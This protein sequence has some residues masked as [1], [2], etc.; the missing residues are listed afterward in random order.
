[1]KNLIP[2]LILFAYLFINPACKKDK[3]KVYK[4][5]VLTG[6]APQ[7]LEELQDF[8][9]KD[10]NVIE[11]GLT[12]YGQDWLENL[13][14]LSNLEKVNGFVTIKNNENLIS[15]EGLDN[16][17]FIYNKDP[18]NGNLSIMNNNNLTNIDGL[19]GL[20]IIESGMF[21]AENEKLET[22]EGLNNLQELHSLYIFNNPNLV[23]LK[24]FGNSIVSIVGII[25]SHSEN[26]KII[27][28]FE[29]LKE[30]D[31]EL[32][33]YENPILEKLTAFKK[34]K[35][36]GNL[37]LSNNKKLYDISGLDNLQTINIS[38]R[39]VENHSLSNLLN[40]SNIDTIYRSLI[41]KDCPLLKSL[42]G[43]SSARFVRHN[44]ELH[45]IENDSLVNLCAIQE[46]VRNT[47]H[48]ASYAVRDN[49]F[50]PSKEDLLNGE[51]SIE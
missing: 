14:L 25:I 38:L 40:L 36:T 2:I 5:D 27:D 44:S 47:A 1:M 7:S 29:I 6:F 8:Y 22:C 10:Y 12:L 34:L 37:N 20:K 50:N 35:A 9:D 43:L 41:I 45:I 30:I 46:L 15:L 18:Y 4:G 33:I 11:N 48:W 49:A 21:I 24:G 13:Y 51:C 28:G 39:L 16:L 26:L 17:N 23:N 3:E 32:G 42:D 19:S 31:H